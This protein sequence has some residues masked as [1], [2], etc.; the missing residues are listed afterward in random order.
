[1]TFG[2]VLSV[3]VSILI[4]NVFIVVHEFGHYITGKKL[5][6]EFPE[7][8][9]GMGP[10]L[11]GWH[12]GETDFNIRAFPIG[13]FCRF[14]GEDEDAG[15]NPRAMHNRP[16]WARM[17][18]TAAGSLMNILFAIVL[19]IATL[20]IFGDLAV[21]DHAYIYQVV[22]NSPAQRAGIEAGDRILSFEGMEVTTVESAVEAIGS[23]SGNTAKIVVERDG[24]EVTLEVTPEY[25]EEDGSYKIGVT[26]TQGMERVRLPFFKCIT[27][28]FRQVWAVIASVF[29]FLGSLFGSLFRKLFVDH[30]TAIEGTEDV[31]SI[32]GV[33][34]IMSVAVRENLEL[35]LWLAITISANLG[36]MNML[37]IPA[38]DGSRFMF[39]LFELITKRRVK[40]ERE[41]I[42]HLI[43]MALLLVLFVILGWRDITRLIG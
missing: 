29:E 26:L 19:A 11:F 7:F 38:L 40:P 28:A 42:I 5:G 31:M 33:V 12:R 41:G 4:I 20:G 10:K 22:E 27:E 17:I 39:L 24:E 43:G 15:D 30:G 36:V 23:A 16:V 1:M 18:V 14:V 8:S 9:I 2:S 37:P 3:I 25:K 32:V 35:L 6:F 13:G 21:M 34:G